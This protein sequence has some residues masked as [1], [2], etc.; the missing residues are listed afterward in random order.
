MGLLYAIN[1]VHT[2]ENHS[3]FTTVLY[4][5]VFT[6]QSK[7]QFLAQYIYCAALSII[8]M[9]TEIMSTATLSLVQNY[10]PSYPRKTWN[11]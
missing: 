7:D 9:K 3:S 5:A 6:F 2:C 8:S 11:A 1:S 4:K 10:V